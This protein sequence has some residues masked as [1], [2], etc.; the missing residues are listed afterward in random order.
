[1]QGDRD[2][3]TL[4]NIIGIDLTD[5]EYRAGKLR[6]AELEEAISRATPTH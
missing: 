3:E 6:A 1:M 2:A 5:D 4:R